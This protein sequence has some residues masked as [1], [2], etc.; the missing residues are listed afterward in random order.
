MSFKRCFVSLAATA[1]VLSFSG[2]YAEKQPNPFTDCGIGGAIFKNDTAAV[3]SNVI[4]DL[5]TTAVTS[6]VVSPDTCEGFNVEAAVFIH[7]SY[8]NLVEETTKGSGAHLDAL[9][10][11]VDVSTELKGQIV[12]GLRARIA[13]VV[14]DEHYVETDLSEKANFYYSQLM[15]AI[16]A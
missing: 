8:Q 1:A 3:I 9:L 2:A 14:S 4:W 13:E 6:A 5:G 16:Q 10:N 15:D 12:G 7:E 11:I